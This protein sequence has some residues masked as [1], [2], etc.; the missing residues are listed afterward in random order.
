MD[1]ETEKEQ[2][3]LPEALEDLLAD[4]SVELEVLVV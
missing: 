4:L 2:V 3:D 1:L